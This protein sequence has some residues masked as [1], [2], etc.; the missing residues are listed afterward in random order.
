MAKQQ[1]FISYSGHDAFEAGLLQFALEAM[2]SKEGVIAWTFERDQPRSQRSIAQGLKR[3]V[4]ESVATIF[5]VSPATLDGGAAQWVELG[6][7]DAF[8]VATFVLLHHLDFKDI[9]LRERGIPPLLLERQCSLARE[10]KSIAKEI[11]KLVK[12]GNDHG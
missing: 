2:L 10:W 5:L 7:S 1:I 3:R 4:R 9:R 12:K 11:R 8:D 6:W